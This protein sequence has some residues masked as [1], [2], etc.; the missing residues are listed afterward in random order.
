MVASSLI[1]KAPTLIYFGQEVGEDGSE[2]AGFGK[3]SR[4]SI[5]DYIGVPA[6][7]KWMNDGKFD[8]GLLTSQE[9]GLR[10]FYVSLLNLSQENVFANGEFSPLEINKDKTTLLAFTRF[11]EQQ[12]YIVINQ[13]DASEAKLEVVVANKLIKKWQLNDGKYTLVDALSVAT[14]ELIVKGGQGLIKLKIPSLG[15]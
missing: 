6:H 15:S 3:P 12:I 1:S 10:D 14:N 4:T 5:F 8:G 7:Q 13:F 2:D 9:Q 11:D